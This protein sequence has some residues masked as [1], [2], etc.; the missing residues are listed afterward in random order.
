[1]QPLVSAVIPTYNYGRYLSRAVDSV[2]GQTHAP[3][4]CIVVDDGSTDDTLSV[5]ARYR[6]RIRVIT[7]LNSGAPAAKNTGIR[8]ATGDFIALLDADDWWE[9]QKIERQLRVFG[10]NPGLG[11]VGCGVRQ[12]DRL[13]RE[14][15]LEIRPQPVSQWQRNLRAIATRNLWVGGSQSGILARKTVFDEIGPFDESLGAAED[16]DMWM[17]LVA[18]Y[19]IYN[20]GD[21]L[22]NIERHGAG[23]FR[24]ARRAEE[25]QWRVY[26]KAVAEW[27]DV[28]DARTR[29]RMR[30]LIF[31][32]AGGE[33]L[34]AG[35]IPL[36]LTKYVESLRQWPFHAKR[37]SI[38]GRLA[39]KSA[40]SLGRPTCAGSAPL[41]EPEIRSRGIK[42]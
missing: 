37:W 38:A 21:I 25:N 9:P 42:R 41:N 35:E 34:S 6:D 23:V 24:N 15:L 18:R 4:E 1:M 32:D 27:P 14:L 19:S 10:Q 8:T 26:R 12:V 7:Q 40:L 5:L 39:A 33:L 31:A 20:L 2:L 3:I 29:R 11:A 13:G 30:A 28:L 17:R 22:V 16:W 36:A